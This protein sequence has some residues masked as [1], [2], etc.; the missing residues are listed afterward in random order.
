[1]KY[2]LHGNKIQ[3]TVED[4][5][6]EAVSVICNGKERLWQNPTGEWSGHAPVLFPVCGNCAMTVQGTKYPL[7][8]HGFAKR[9]A[10]R[11]A[12]QGEDFLSFVLHSSEETKKV[13][14]YD[15]A[16]RVTYRIAKNRLSVEYQIFNTGVNPIYASCGGHESFALEGDVGDYM[17][18]FPI[19]ETFTALLHDEAGRLTGETAELG[20]GKTLFL[21]A[22]FLRES[23]TLIL[24]VKSRSAL[25]RRRTG[26]NVARVFFEEFPYLLLWRPQNAK[27]ICIEPWHN[28]PDGKNPPE[29][30]Q[31][32]GVFCVPAGGEKRFVR[33][34]EY[35]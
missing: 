1:M 3:L 31:K 34:I 13:Y 5:G 17:L 24:R 7:P 21:P 22:E 2:R 16:F 10:F 8:R 33:T 25:L 28:L 14:P 26:E 15:F 32:E 9:S 27:M 35:L 23:A 19:A 18:D 29:F 30:A 11:L 4:F 6:A 20:T 12:G